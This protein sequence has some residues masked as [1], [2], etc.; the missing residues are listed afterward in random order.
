MFEETPALW[1]RFLCVPIFGSIATRTYSP[2]TW[3]TQEQMSCVP[4]LTGKSR[5]G[6]RVTWFARSPRVLGIW[7]L[8]NLTSVPMLR[9]ARWSLRFAH[10]WNRRKV[11]SEIPHLPRQYRDGTRMANLQSLIDRLRPQIIFVAILFVGL[12]H[13]ACYGQAV[14]DAGTWMSVNTLGDIHVNSRD[15]PRFKWWFDGHL[16]LFDD[17]NGF[18]QSIVRPAVGYELNENL[19]FWVGYG[20]ISET[21]PGGTNFDE[22]RI[23]QQLLWSRSRRQSKLTSRTRLEQRFVGRGDDTGWRLRQFYKFLRPFEFEP[24]LS[25]VVWD[26]AFFDLNSTDWGQSG[27]FSQNRVFTGFGWTLE[28]LPQAPR[29]EIGY[30]HQYIHRQGADDTHNH[31]VGINWFARF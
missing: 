6:V 21:P 8:Q 23:F 26:E 20:W 5:C 25:A 2:S 9:A 12:E 27:G 18:G 17:A 7:T 22:N 10:R 30:M 1:K 28:R 14:H 3:P 19:T 4:F 16:R 29:I 11:S 24:R 13:Q 31:I 15:E